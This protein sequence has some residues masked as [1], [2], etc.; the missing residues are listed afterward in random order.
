MRTF[1]LL[2]IGGAAAVISTAQSAPPKQN[3]QP[4]SKQLL[5][6]SIS[7]PEQ[8]VALGSEIKVK[9]KLTNIADHVLNL[10]DPTGIA[11]TWRRC[12]ATR[13]ILCR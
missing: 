12:A 10:V 9:T 4:F 1:A 2:L 7:V 11:T 5:S 3:E 13:V 8:T 6:L